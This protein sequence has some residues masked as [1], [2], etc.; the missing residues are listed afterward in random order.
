M[1]CQDYIS[2]VYLGPTPFQSLSLLTTV[3]WGATQH[4]GMTLEHMIDSLKQALRDRSIGC[5]IDH[6]L[7]RTHFIVPRIPQ[8]PSI[9]F[10]GDDPDYF[11]RFSVDGYAVVIN[12]LLY[13]MTH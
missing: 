1:Q 5:S 6:P 2:R 9:N 12:V 3:N 13:A 10:A 8:I 7:F 11:H 4:L